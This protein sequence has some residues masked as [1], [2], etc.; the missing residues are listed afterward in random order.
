MK[1]ENWKKM[2]KVKKS[3]DKKMQNKKLKKV[4]ILACYVEVQEFRKRKK[5]FI[6]T[7][8]SLRKKK[9][10]TAFSVFSCLPKN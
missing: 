10:F 8:T 2:I 4:R 9:S 6:F 1:E 7:V 5:L 3:R